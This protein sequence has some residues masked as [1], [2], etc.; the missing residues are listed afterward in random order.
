MLSTVIEDTN[1]D[2]TE[3]VTVVEIEISITNGKTR[4]VTTVAIATETIIRSLSLKL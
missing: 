2:N 3:T 4:D 1:P